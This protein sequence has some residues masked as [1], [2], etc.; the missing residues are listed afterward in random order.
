MLNGT[1][2]TTNGKRQ[3]TKRQIKKPCPGLIRGTA[4][5]FYGSRF[6]VHPAIAGPFHAINTCN[7]QA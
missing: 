1:R 3:T 5:Y 6:T 2:E 7:A 4:C